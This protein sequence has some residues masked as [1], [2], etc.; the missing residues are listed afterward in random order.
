MKVAL[1]KIREKSYYVG[2]CEDLEVRL[3]DHITDWA[4]IEDSD[5]TDLW[6][7]SRKHGYILLVLP[8][9]RQQDFVAKTIADFREYAAKQEEK[10]AAKRKKYLA[11]NKKNEAK[12][13]EAKVKRLQAQ[14]EKLGVGG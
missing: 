7:A 11:A 5:Y 2:D 8:E 14:L 1:V 10:E 12:K 13:K 4:E 3:V 6:Q 9:E